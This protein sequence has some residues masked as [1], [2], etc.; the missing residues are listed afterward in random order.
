[1]NKVVEKVEGF[2][3]RLKIALRDVDYS[4]SIPTVLWREFNFRYT[5]SAITVHGARK[6]LMGASIPTQDK[7]RVLAQWLGVPIN[8]LR[9]GEDNH[10]LKNGQSLDLSK[11]FDTAYVRLIAELQSL[12][13]N[14]QILARE[15]MRLL[16]RMKGV[17]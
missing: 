5:G 17:Q 1:M 7:L 16:I 8:W 14:S 10:K 13:E 11:R 2:S 9:Y 4:S 15:F 12:D 3:T 6:W